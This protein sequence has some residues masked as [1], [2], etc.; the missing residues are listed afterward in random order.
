MT[1]KYISAPAM[2]LYNPKGEI[3][4]SFYGPRGGT[5]GTIP[6]TRDAARKLARD[7]LDEL[8]R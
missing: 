4:L 5:V 8:E 3:I 6:L 7:I 2:G 1:V